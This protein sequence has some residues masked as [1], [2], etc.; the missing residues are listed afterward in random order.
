MLNDENIEKGIRKFITKVDELFN[1]TDVIDQYYDK[2]NNTS[3]NIHSFY[4]NVSARKLFKLMLWH[5]TSDDL[6]YCEL[7][8]TMYVI[9]SKGTNLCELTIGTKFEP[10]V[11]DESLSDEEYMDKLISHINNYS[12][13]KDNDKK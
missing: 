4:A 12:K 5:E 3:D 2:I 8:C 11:F 1:N 10:F 7:K 13:C 6:I 9:Q